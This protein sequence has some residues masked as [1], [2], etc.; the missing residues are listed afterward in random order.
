MSVNL[1]LVDAFGWGSES[2][3][4]VAI[5]RLRQENIISTKKCP[6]VQLIKSE[7]IRWHS[8]ILKILGYI[9]GINVI[10]G[11][12]AMA[13]AQNE[14]ELRPHNKQFW[15]GRGVAMIFTG[16][17]LAIADLAK[18]IFDCTITAKYNRENKRLIEEFNVLHEHKPKYSSG[19]SVGDS[20]YC[21]TQEG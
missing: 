11:I 3:A 20:V 7:S 1:Y 8:N 15:I 14:E 9:P 18:F 16:P 17:F 19:D 4:K 5:S 12:I 21:C 10:A 2:T 6:K 13:C